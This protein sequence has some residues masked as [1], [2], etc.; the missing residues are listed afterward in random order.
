VAFYVDGIKKWSKT[1]AS[2]ADV[3]L[4]YN[5]KKGAHTI[6]VKISGGFITTEK[7]VVK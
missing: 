6:A 1:S 2:D 3:V 5:L 7:F 4:N